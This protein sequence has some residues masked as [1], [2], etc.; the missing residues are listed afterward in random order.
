MT[1]QHAKTPTNNLNHD[2]FISKYLVNYTV[3]MF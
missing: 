3:D 2:N 1:E